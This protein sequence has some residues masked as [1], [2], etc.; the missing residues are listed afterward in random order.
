MYLFFVREY[1]VCEKKD[2]SRR[3]TRWVKSKRKKNKGEKTRGEG[4]RSVG[5][6]YQLVSFFMPQ[7]KRYKPKRYKLKVEMVRKN[8]R[9]KKRTKEDN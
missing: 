3:W 2:T 7:R 1:E 9:G 8:Q 6:M 4:K 5:G